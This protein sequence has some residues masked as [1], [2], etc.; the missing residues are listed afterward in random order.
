[1][2]TK[3]AWGLLLGIVAVSVSSGASATDTLDC[4]APPYYLR[5]TVSGEY[6]AQE[7][8]LHKENA[9]LA[10]GNIKQW[11]RFE[12][13]WPDGVSPVGVPIAVEIAGAASGHSMM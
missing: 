5:V 13:Q 3:T 6:G 1:M 12:L 4:E 10:E 9:V 2:F 11:S 7:F 8:S